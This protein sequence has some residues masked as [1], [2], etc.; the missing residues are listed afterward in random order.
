M[1]SLQSC[2]WNI[3]HML[4][5]S[6]AGP[7]I[8]APSEKDETGGC[9]LNIVPSPVGPLDGLWKNHCDDLDKVMYRGTERITVYGTFSVPLRSRA[10]RQ[11]VRSQGCGDPQ[12]QALWRGCENLAWGR[13]WRGLDYADITMRSSIGA[14]F[15]RHALDL[16]VYA[17]RV[18]R[19]DQ[20]C[21]GATGK[22]RC[23]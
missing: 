11:G 4:D 7:E 2:C 9:L 17:G 5:H 14:V 12:R 15:S 19:R 8:D 18:R 23:R 20:G 21:H 10:R 13:L 3:T 22:S 6:Y 1:S 16:G